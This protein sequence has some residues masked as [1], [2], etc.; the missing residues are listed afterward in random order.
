MKKVK[1]FT[2]K[3]QKRKDE[4]TKILSQYKLNKTLDVLVK[5]E[6]FLCY[7]RELFMLDHRILCLLF[8]LK[9]L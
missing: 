5:E 8:L 1:K 2:K 4:A 7:D 3:S 9:M 6:I